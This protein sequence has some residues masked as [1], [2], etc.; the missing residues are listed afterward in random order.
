MS[1]YTP[2]VIIYYIKIITKP[3]IINTHKFGKRLLIICS[4]IQVSLTN[5]CHESN[6]KTKINLQNRYK[7]R[8]KILY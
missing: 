4:V 8:N 3:I 2:N 6:C 1:I 5:V 7:M